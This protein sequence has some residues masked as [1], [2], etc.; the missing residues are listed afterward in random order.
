MKINFIFGLLLFSPLFFISCAVLEQE[1]GDN[2]I[3]E[4]LFEGNAKDTS[5]N[6]NDGVVSG[7]TLV[8]DRFGKSDNAYRF[9]SADSDEIV[10]ADSPE[11][12]PTNA[13]SVTL[14]V[15]PTAFD[16][17]GRIISKRDGGDGGW[18]IDIYGDQIRFTRHGSV[19]LGYPTDTLTVDEW[20][21]VGMTFADG[22][23]HMYV[24]GE[25]VGSTS[26]PMYAVSTTDL[27]IGNAAWGFES[28]FSGDIDDV[29][30][31]HSILSDDEIKTL[32]HA[33]GWDL[34]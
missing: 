10:V 11:L 5:G 27:K 9:V 20:I 22:E 6:G 33:G 4:Y 25:E 16:V 28:Y 21:F 30:L 19:M 3:A 34:L 29:R 14:W 24:N 18:E 26:Q 2:L 32:Y 12:N 8:S 7:A 15:K 1:N 31:Y 17:N 23:Q 13:L